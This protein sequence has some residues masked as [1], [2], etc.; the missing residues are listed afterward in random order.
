M[1]VQQIKKISDFFRKVSLR[2]G[3]SEKHISAILV[4]HGVDQQKKRNCVSIDQMRKHLDYLEK[5]YKIIKLSELVV[6]LKAGQIDQDYAVLTFDDAYVNVSEYAYSELVRRKLP[7]TI[8]VPADYI[9]R[10]NVWD[11]DRDPE[12][13][14]YLPVMS[15]Q[16]L[17]AL[18]P[19]LIELGSHSLSHGHMSEMDDR[20]LLDE[21]QESKTILEQKIN[22][23]V[24][25][26]AFPYGQLTDFDSRAAALLEKC[27]Y[28]GGCTT[29]FSRFNQQADP[30]LLN[31]IIVWDDDQAIDLENKLSGYYDWLTGKEV[32]VNK[33]A[34]LTSR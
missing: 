31:R 22:R 19:E 4:Y 20:T 7:A 29:H 30:Y 3:R 23:A 6:R 11:Y 16:Q 18:D 34:R 27:G 12:K 2:A 24:R 10:Y 25:Y 17:A 13:Y 28:D 32:I 26:F 33:L 21:I 5:N 14:P 9:G 15:Q 8:F 1:T